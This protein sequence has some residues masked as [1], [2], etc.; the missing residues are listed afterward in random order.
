MCVRERRLGK[1]GE[2]EA[3]ERDRKVRGEEVCILKEACI[4][5]SHFRQGG[6]RRMEVTGEK[7]GERCKEMWEKDERPKQ[8]IRIR[9]REEAVQ[10]CASLQM[11]MSL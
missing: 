7:R 2:K 11:V 5:M 10:W 4:V 3:N 6:W 8:Y 1:E 9:I